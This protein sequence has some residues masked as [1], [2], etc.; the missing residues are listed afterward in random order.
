MRRLRARD[1]AVGARD[2]PGLLTYADACG[3]MR[4]YAVWGA[5][6][7]RLFAPDA[8]RRQAVA[9]ALLII[10]CFTSTKVQILTPQE[11]RAAELTPYAD[12]PRMLAY[13][14]VC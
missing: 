4:T 14:D 6:L 8:V 2:A 12:K 1:R 13:A 10:T 7:G 5:V 9:R 3:R 11:L